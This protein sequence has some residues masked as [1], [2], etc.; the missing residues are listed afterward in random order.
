MLLLQT[1]IFLSFRLWSWNVRSKP[2]S[3]SLLLCFIQ[4]S[5]L[6]VRTYMKCFLKSYVGAENTHG[7]GKYHCTAGLQM[8]WIGFNQARRYFFVFTETTESKPVKQEIVIVPP[9]VSVLWLEPIDSKCVR[10][11]SVPI[12]SV[13]RWLH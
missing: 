12:C 6:D 10:W 7:R 4:F 9:T 13:I 8:N 3:S 2:S 1:I 11:L 5:W